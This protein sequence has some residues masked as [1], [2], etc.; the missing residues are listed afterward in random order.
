MLLFFYPT[1]YRNPDQNA[2]IVQDTSFN[3]MNEH[4]DRVSRRLEHNH[5]WYG[6]QWSAMHAY[7][8]WFL[9]R[10]QGDGYQ[11]ENFPHY[12]A[13]SLKMEERASVQRAIA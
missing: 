11:V 1:P 13:H 4:F 10:M 8:C 6:D 12:V 9:W 3:A 2:G 7:L 5:R